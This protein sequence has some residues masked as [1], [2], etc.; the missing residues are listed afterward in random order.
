MRSIVVTPA[1]SAIVGT[2]LM[3]W[4]RSPWMIRV[5]PAPSCV[6][7][8]RA[9]TTEYQNGIASRMR[10]PLPVEEEY[11][12]G[13]RQYGSQPEMT[14][15]GLDADVADTDGALATG[16]SRA[17]LVTRTAATRAGRRAGSTMLQAAGA[18]ECQDAVASADLVPE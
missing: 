1:S 13:M 2:T 18:G 17:A 9:L 15:R 8:R 6:P 16:A 14:R 10:S 4:L 11:A 3:P 7:M 5:L 12:A